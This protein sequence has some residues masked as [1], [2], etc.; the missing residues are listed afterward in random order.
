M[1]PKIRELIQ[2]SA[3]VDTLREAA[4]AMGMTKL[5]VSGIKKIERGVTTIEEVLKA[6]HEKE[7]LT[8]IC[9]HCSRTVSL[10]FKDCP[11]CNKP[12]VPTCKS[13]NRILQPDWVVC[14][15]CRTNLKPEK[16]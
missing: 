10:D 5:G 1:G 12:M 14:P 8:A 6:V 3:T 7:E 9:P 16:Q 2:A 15:Y 13:C 4:M 11:Y